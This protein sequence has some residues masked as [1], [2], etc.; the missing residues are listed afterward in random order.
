VS[1]NPFTRRDIVNKYEAWYQT[2]GIRVDIQE[3]SLLKELLKIFPDVNSILEVGCGTG[4]FTRWFENECGLIA[5][6]M[7]KSRAML[8]E[9]KRYGSTMLIEGDAGNIPLSSNV[10][11]ISIFITTMEFLSNPDIAIRE[12][13]RVSRMGII[14]GTINSSSLLGMKY[15]KIDG[16]IWGKAHFLSISRLKRIIKRAIGSQTEVMWRTTLW[17]ILP[18]YLP[19]PWGGFIGMSI[20]WD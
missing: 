4:H 5:Y 8:I 18:G 1:I 17:P 20:Q 9:A 11:D 19:L 12:A 10:V 3:K 7:D 16:P 13:Y 14:I 15:R 6:G 2:S